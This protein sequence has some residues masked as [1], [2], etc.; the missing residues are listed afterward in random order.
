MKLARCSVKQFC[1]F[2][3]EMLAA[4]FPGMTEEQIVHKIAADQQQQAMEMQQVKQA[5]DAFNAAGAKGGG[6]KGG[7]DEGYMG[8]GAWHEGRVVLDGFDKF[9][10]NPTNRCICRSSCNNIHNFLQKTYESER[11]DYWTEKQ[12]DLIQL[13]RYISSGWYENIA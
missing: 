1:W 7:G 4:M 2:F 12:C 5:M 3:S 9:E 6:A 8:K 10:G 13:L 11:L